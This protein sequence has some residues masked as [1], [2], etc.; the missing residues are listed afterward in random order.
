VILATGARYRRLDVPD[1][2]RFEGVG[3]YYAA[4]QVEA[5]HCA[6]RPVVVIGGGNSAGQAAVFL[7]TR[8]PL[9]H[10]LIR[11]DDLSATMSRYLIDQ[12]EREPGIR[13]HPRTELVGL[14]G[15]QRLEQARVRTHG[16]GESDLDAGSVFVFI[17]AQAHTG[18]LDGY[19][20]TDRAGFVL[21]GSDTGQTETAFLGT[22]RPGVF[23]AGD[24]RA[25][26][27]KRVAT[28]VGEGSQAVTFVHQHLAATFAVI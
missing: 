15:H 9:V 8:A 1:L 3:L 6:D 11:R 19:V 12:I 16:A 5:S 21:T 27:T 20:T 28:A 17:G 14:Y 7:A 25:G 22:S 13:L 10:L 2:A 23:A 24:V 18:W 4:T 26:S